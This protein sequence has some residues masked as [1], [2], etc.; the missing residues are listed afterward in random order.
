MQYE[1]QKFGF[2][3]YRITYRNMIIPRSTALTAYPFVFCRL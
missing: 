3:A 1:G 2:V